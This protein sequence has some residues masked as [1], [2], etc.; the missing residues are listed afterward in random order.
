MGIRARLGGVFEGKP[1]EAVARMKEADL[2][3]LATDNARKLGDKV[4]LTSLDKRTLV[5]LVMAQ[6]K[7]LSA[8]KGRE[9]E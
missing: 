9:G 6:A 7:R 1:R 2:R 8:K 3:D 5:S 4:D